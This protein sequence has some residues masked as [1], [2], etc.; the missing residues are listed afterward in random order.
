MTDNHALDTV[1]GIVIEN[2]Q[3]VVQIQ[4]VAFQLGVNNG[5]GTFVAL[6]AFA[7]KYLYVDYRAAHAGG[8]TQ[9]GIF[10]I[11]GFFTEDGTQQFFFR[12]EL[13]F[14]FGRYFAH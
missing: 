8:H 2:T 11:G 12:R 3:L 10:H 14:A 13:G 1:E 4:A 6:D 5:L 9:R 7:G